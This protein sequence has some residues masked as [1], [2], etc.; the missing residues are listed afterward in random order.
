MR[1]SAIEGHRLWASVYDSSANPLLALERRAM[2]DLLKPLRPSRMIDVACGTGQWLLHFQRGGSEVFG[3]DACREMLSKAMTNVSLQG[4]VA[5]GD[6]ERIPFSGSMAE[7]VLCSLSLGYFHNIHRVFVELARA[8][9]PG[10][11]VAVSDLHPSALAAGWTR[12]F[13]L[14]E[15]RYDLEHYC[16]SMQ[17][18]ESA[19]SNAGLRLK[20]C[21]ETYFDAPELP[22]F[23]YAGKEE[24]FRTATSV[25]ALFIGLWEKPCC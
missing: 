7:L 1:V 5:L 10:G 3:C 25:P 12:S 11:F 13:K 22:L 4:R 17:Q 14:G 24:L 16:R 6:A 19:A 20:S 23:R 21:H 8:S 18:L 2:G 15:Q 9:K